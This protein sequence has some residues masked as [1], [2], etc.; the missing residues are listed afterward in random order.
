M[1]DAAFSD[2]L[3]RIRAGDEEAGAELVRRYE[4]VIR[5]EV[6]MRLGDSR[7]RFGSHDICQSAKL[8]GFGERQGG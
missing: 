5:L 2:F 1:D 7:L 3:R 8:S 6:R 4:S